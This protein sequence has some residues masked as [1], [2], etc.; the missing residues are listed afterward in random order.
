[1]VCSKCH[2]MYNLEDCIDGTEPK[3]CC[4]VAFPNHP[5]ISKRAPCNSVLLKKVKCGSTYKYIPKKLYLYNNII[6]NLQSLLQRPGTLRL[7]SQWK[8]KP[9]NSEMLTDITDGQVWK[10]FLFVNGRPLLEI[11]T[12]LALILNVDWFT[13]YEH[14]QY[15]VG[16]IY[17]VIANLSRCERYKLENVL[18]VGC[19]P[20]PSE[21]KH[22]ITT[23]LSF[24][25]NELEK[26]WD[27]IPFYVD[28]NRIPITIRAALVAVVCDIPACRKVCGFTGFQAKLGCSKCLKMFHSRAFGEKLDYSEYDR[29]HWP[30]RNILQHM[31]SL[32]KLTTARSPSELSSLEAQ[33]GARYSVLTRLPYFDAIKH[34]VVDPMHNLYL[35]TSKNMVKIWKEMSLLRPEHFDVIQARI[36]ELNVPYGIGRIPNKIHS[37]FSGLTAD[38]WRNWTNLF[39]LY[40]LRDIL[41]PDHYLCWSFFVQAS[42]VFCQHSISKSALEFAD[43]KLIQFCKMFEELYGTERCTPNMHLHGHLKECILNYGPISS[44]WA[45]AF[46]GTMGCWRAL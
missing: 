3:T 42:V 8:E 25:V 18:V 30:Q 46:E 43:K 26:L 45:F 13:P 32:E 7:L 19:I 16:V 6:D 12:N 29:S 35:G 10:D 22:S 4:Y 41:P 9:I 21:P 39:S 34:H 27:G 33:S 37:K 15:S 28:S 36:D 1:M 2:S 20:G 5:L 44:F 17:L 14:S 23:Y 11:V 40:A 38:Q 31:K 24:V